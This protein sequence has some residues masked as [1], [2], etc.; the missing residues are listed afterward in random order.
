MP[1]IRKRGLPRRVATPAQMLRA[2]FVAAA[3]A[4]VFLWTLREVPAGATAVAP[5]QVF[6]AR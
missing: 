3:F 5:D 6:A 2:V 1:Q 4:L